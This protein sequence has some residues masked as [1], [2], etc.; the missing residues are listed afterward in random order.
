MA[1]RTTMIDM[2]GIKRKTQLKVGSLVTWD[3]NG[4]SAP[5]LALY[6]RQLYPEGTFGMLM[7]IDFDNT[8]PYTVRWFFRNVER[9]RTSQM[10]AWTLRA[11]ERS[12]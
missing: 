10:A 11:Y 9:N 4:A 12:L 8:H 7:K 1:R 6:W 5:R 2:V 3:E